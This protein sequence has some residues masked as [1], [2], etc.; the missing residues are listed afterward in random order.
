MDIHGVKEIVE[1]FDKST[2][3]EFDLRKGDFELYLSKNESYGRNYVAVPQTPLATPQVA[4]T[5]VASPVPAETPKAEV[6]EVKVEAEGEVVTSPIVGTVYLQP[7]PDKPAYVKVGDTVSEHDTVCIVEA[8]KMMNEI[9]AGISGVVT[10]IL[11]EN[12]QVVG[13]GDALFKIK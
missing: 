8:M 13:I 10:E 3:R 9:P 6:A 1:Q 2:L 12:E 5:P 7:A 4:E 11:V